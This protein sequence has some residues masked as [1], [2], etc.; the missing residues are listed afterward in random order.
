MQQRRPAIP[1]F[2]TYNIPQEE[3]EDLKQSLDRGY[4][5]Q[6]YPQVV[7]RYLRVI[8][9][10][11]DRIDEKD[12]Y[13]YDEYPDKIR[14]ERLTEVVLNLI[15]LEKNMM[16]ETQKNLVQVLIWEEIIQRRNINNLR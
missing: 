6:M 14:L 12:S 1:Y 4:F 5:R 8:A 11:L 2:M 7:K 16:R 9:E 3:S 10:V 13:I 15:P